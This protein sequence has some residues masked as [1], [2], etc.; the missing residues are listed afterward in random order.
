MSD[1]RPPVLFAHERD[2]PRR[3]QDRRAKQRRAPHRPLD[4][5]FAATLVNQIAP[6][7]IVRVKY[8]E[9]RRTR[10]GISFDFE[11]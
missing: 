11:A 7:E 8:P 3:G 10:A 5:L 9:K 1:G 6:P 4:P 2:E